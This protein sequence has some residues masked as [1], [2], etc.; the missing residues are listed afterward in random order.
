MR[1]RAFQKNQWRP[2]RKKL[3]SAVV[4]G[5][6]AGAQSHHASMNARLPRIVTSGSSS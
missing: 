5:L 6:F 3:R 1:T 4:R 2:P